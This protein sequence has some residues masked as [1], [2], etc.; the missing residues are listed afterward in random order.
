MASFSIHVLFFFDQ[1][2]LERE[3]AR[4]REL[5]SRPHHQHLNYQI[6]DRSPVDIPRYAPRCGG[7]NRDAPRPE[8]FGFVTHF[9]DRLVR[10]NQPSSSRRGDERGYMREGI[11]GENG[12]Y[13]HSDDGCYRFDQDGFYYETETGYRCDS[14][15]FLCDEKGVRFTRVK[16]E[17]WDQSVTSFAPPTAPVTRPIPPRTEKIPIA[18]YRA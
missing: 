1:P 14:G 15:G 16:P 8:G 2:R 5:R 4:D 7:S 17:S 12:S 6:R 10:D 13:F 3:R 9:D 18:S 11:C